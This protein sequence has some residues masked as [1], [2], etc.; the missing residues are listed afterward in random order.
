LFSFLAG[1]QLLPPRKRDMHYPYFNG[2][3]F[4]YTEF[5]GYIFI[6]RFF[7]SCF[8]FIFR[9]DFRMVEKININVSGA[10]FN[11]VKLP[12]SGPQFSVFS[13]RFSVFSSEFPVFSSQFSVPSA[14]FP[15]PRLV[16]IN[17][18]AAP[19]AGRF[20]FASYFF[21]FLF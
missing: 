21:S 20:R 1:L 6:C 13:V 10:Y 5:Y 2:I 11:S 17:K 19:F 3:C 12:A 7:L 14:N 9:A 18:F 15:D 16:C 4:F 8:L